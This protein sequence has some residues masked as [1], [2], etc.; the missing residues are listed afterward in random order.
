MMIDKLR[1]WLQHRTLF[2]FTDIEEDE[3]NKTMAIR[4]VNNL[5][6][7]LVAYRYRKLVFHIQVRLETGD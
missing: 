7:V 2:F 6:R 5:V 1:S 4:I 3:G